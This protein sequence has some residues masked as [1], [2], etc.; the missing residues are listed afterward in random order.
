MIRDADFDLAVRQRAH[1][2]VTFACTANLREPVRSLTSTPHVLISIRS[3]L[4]NI[5]RCARRAV[6]RC[7]PRAAAANVDQNARADCRLDRARAMARF[8]VGEKVPLVISP[9]GSPADPSWP[10]RSRPGDCAAPRAP[11]ARARPAIAPSLAA[12]T[13][14]SRPMKSRSS[15]LES[16]R[17]G[18]AGL[19]GMA[20]LVHVVAVQIHA[21]LEAQRVPCAEPGGRRRLCDQRAP[22][23]RRLR[24]R[25]HDLEAV[26][27]G[28]AGA[29]EKPGIDGAAEN[30]GMPSA[31]RDAW[32]TGAS[33]S[34]RGRCGPCTPKMARSERSRTATPKGA[35][36]SRIHARSFRRVPAFTTSRN[37]SRSGNRR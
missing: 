29:R 28:I 3:K 22:R 13:S 19:E 20:G 4:I 33:R 31:V 14:A 34:C 36:C 25:Q 21:R 17:P 24:P 18:E 10:P 7:A 35:A 5:Y 6:L 37:Q 12:R 32:R 30:R 15:R 11:R 8:N 9:S 23:L 2:L 26:L 27:A 1:P 16:H